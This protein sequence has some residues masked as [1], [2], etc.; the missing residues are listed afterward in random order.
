M[1]NGPKKSQKIIMVA[2]GVTL[3]VAGFIL[4]PPLIEALGNKLYKA[5]STKEKIDF[6]NLGPEIIPKEERP[7]KEGE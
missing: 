6:A 4:I 3:T 2:G 1:K 7:V 5:S